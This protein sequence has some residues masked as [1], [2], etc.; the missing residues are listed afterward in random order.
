MK[1]PENELAQIVIASCIA[2]HIND[3]VISPGSRNAPLTIGFNQFPNIN[4]L[5]VVDER[6]AAFVAL[7][8]A[9]QTRK[10]SALVCTSGSALLNYYPAV[11][12]AFYANIPLIV[13]SADRPE[14]LIDIGDG[15]TIRQE[16]VLKNHILY[17]ANLTSIKTELDKA[18]NKTLVYQA[19]KIANEQRGPVHIN[20]PFDEP[21]Y[22]LVD[23]IITYPKEICPEAH[24]LMETQSFLEK[25]FATDE[26]EAY[27][28]QWNKATKKVVLI[29]V[30]YPCDLIKVQ[31]DHLMKDPSVVVL[32]ETTSNLNNERTINSI[33]QFLENLTEEDKKWFQ[34]DIL[35]TIGGLVVSKRIKQ[36]FRTYQPKRHWTA[37][38][39]FGYDTFFCLTKHFKI[40]PQLFFSQFFW[41]TQKT[42]SNYQAKALE[43]KKKAKQ[44]HR[45]FS[46]NV[47]YSDF[48]VFD[49]INKSLPKNSIL[50]LSNSA[51]IRYAQLFDIDDSIHVYCNRGTSGIDG[52]TSTA[53]GC[54]IK[55]EK[56]VTLVTGDISFLYD[57]NALWNHYIPNNFRIIIVNNN[58]GGIFK[59]LPGPKKTNALSFF[60]TPHHLTAK[61]LGAMYG[62]NYCGVSN[63]DDLEKELITFYNDS[64]QPKILEVF[65]P[66]EIND[67]VLKTYFESFKK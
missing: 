46:E 17:E 30:N 3:V 23:E 57:S 12:E 15:Q 50:Q 37:H 51:T 24:M 8:M 18:F 61:H 62:F 66:S 59:I 16:G 63:K 38:Q 40:S 58:G 65:T 53:M 13:I 56:Q 64:Q 20:A 34:P 14:H 9:Q 39:S 11:A 48:K 45:V 33:D 26:L 22:N 31:I 10:P 32:T 47:E 35:L 36:F 25:P 4:T 55:S 52:S 2:N 19:I 41:L 21:L 28:T 49:V 42:V 43:I 1:Y 60:E 44:L 6:C 29:G 54:A 27:A 5:S 7:G 67:D